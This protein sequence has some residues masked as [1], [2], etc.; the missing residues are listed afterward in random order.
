MAFQSLVYSSQHTWGAHPCCYPCSQLRQLRLKEAKCFVQEHHR[1]RV[2]NHA[3]IQSWVYSP[4]L[5]K[6]PW[7]VVCRG[8]NCKHSP[9]IAG[10]CSLLGNRWSVDYVFWSDLG[11]K[12]KGLEE[13]KAGPL[14]F[15]ES[16]RFETLE[17]WIEFWQVDR[18][19]SWWE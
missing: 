9:F 2:T 4:T 1:G 3:F 14:R 7:S 16:V 5:G 13:E 18:G 10:T 19:W 8:G 17:R 6:A 11:G 15:L 12:D